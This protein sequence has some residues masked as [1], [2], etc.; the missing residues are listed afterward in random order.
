VYKNQI[1]IIILILINS[2]SSSFPDVCPRLF[3]M[4]K[5]RPHSTNTPQSYSS[6]ISSHPLI[7]LVLFN[8]TSILYCKVNPYCLLLYSCFR[9]SNMRRG[10]KILRENTPLY[11]LTK[12]LLSLYNHIFDELFIKFPLYSTSI[13]HII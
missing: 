5:D 11:K 2:S 6:H 12:S 3:N 13:S 7:D 1:K 9:F 8:S 4:P 10:F